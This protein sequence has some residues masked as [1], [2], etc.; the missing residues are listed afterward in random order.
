MRNVLAASIALVFASLAC[1][2]TT[3]FPQTS[4]FV[5]CIG[6]FASGC[7]QSYTH[8]FDCSF[9]AAHPSNADQAAA[10]QICKNYATPQQIVQG[11][12]VVSYSRIGGGKGNKCGYIID[13]VICRGFV[14]CI[15]QSWTGCSG[16]SG[17][18]TYT[19]TLDCN[20]AAAHPT[21]TDRAAAQQIANQIKGSGIAP[22]PTFHRI[23]IS[24]PGGKC[25]YTFVQAYMQ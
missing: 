5:A 7:K 14:V 22:A 1:S 21:D 12:E 23:G 16:V 8:L 25:G 10:T 17:H 15:G 20:F 6:E 9:A 4:G 2:Q 3:G 13:Q 24:H 19:E 11:T 18:P